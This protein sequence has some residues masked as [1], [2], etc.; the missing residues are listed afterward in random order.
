MVEGPGSHS[1]LLSVYMC[2]TC[3]YSF[4]Q[5][6]VGPTLAVTSVL[7]MVRLDCLSPRAHH[8]LLLLKKSKCVPSRGLLLVALVF[9]AGMVENYVGP[10][11][12]EFF[13]GDHAVTS[14][15]RTRGYTAVAYEIKV[16]AL[17]HDI[18]SDCGFAF[19]LSLLL[20]MPRGGLVWFCPEHP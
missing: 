16:D 11:C 12:T 9:Q 19:A 20:R 4:A 5:E 6:S 15:M 18:M 1:W 10:D 17:C 8:T 13:A 3:S 7:N 2:A 14:G